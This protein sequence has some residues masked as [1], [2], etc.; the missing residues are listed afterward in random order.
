MDCASAYHP[1]M[2]SRPSQIRVGSSFVGAGVGVGLAVGFGVGE[3]VGGAGVVVGL[4]SSVGAKVI[5]GF[6]LIVAHVA[7]KVLATLRI[8]T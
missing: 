8:F 3:G 5:V 1:S 4:G 6:G 2:A 7:L